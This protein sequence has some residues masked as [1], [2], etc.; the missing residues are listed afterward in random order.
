MAGLT[1]YAAS[2][3]Y[4]HVF[5]KTSTFP[6]DTQLFAALSKSWKLDEG[7]LDEQDGA[8]YSRKA[9][10]FGAPSPGGRGSNTSPVIFGP[11]IG[12]SSWDASL[13]LQIMELS[14]GGPSRAWSVI[15]PPWRVLLNTQ[16]EFAAG[17]I[18]INL[19][20][21]YQP[22]WSPKDLP[23]LWNWTWAGRCGENLTLSHTAPSSNYFITEARDLS[24]FGRHFIGR[25]AGKAPGYRVGV[26]VTDTSWGR[27]VWD[28]YF[29]LLGVHQFANGQELFGNVYDFN[30]MTTAGSFHL[31]AVFTN[32]RGTGIRDLWGVTDQN[33]V[34][35]DQGPNRRVT[36]T[37][38]G[39]TVTLANGT[40]P[41]NGLVVLEVGRNTDGTLL[42]YA[43]GVNIKTH[44]GTLPG[45]FT[46]AGFGYKGSGTSEWDDYL[47]ELIVCA[48]RPADSHLKL[49]R[50]HLLE[51][52]RHNFVERPKS[53]ISNYLADRLYDMVFRG[54]NFTPPANQR[55]AL[56]GR[57]PSRSDSGATIHEPGFSGY[58][59]RIMTWS[60]DALAN[61]RG[62]SAQEAFYAATGDATNPL[63]YW[64]VVDHP[65]VGQGNLLFFAP[66]E[67]ALL[68]LAG[69][70]YRIRAK[71]LNINLNA[72]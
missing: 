53:G 55:I 36:I 71:D 9:V 62:S 35:I 14:A 5:S 22:V 59:R 42:C 2:Q 63:A 52:W 29:P 58:I 47:L 54:I 49:L 51:K 48:G 23:A 18:G 50:Q 33:L 26:S 64:G 20:P 66:L 3:C 43:N 4:R 30:P 67:E 19:T 17:K 10:T 69:V 61:G 45:T 25:M 8:G 13:A 44:S 46:V 56:I 68:P 1:D 15:R 12:S 38:A 32:S 40:L 11:A 37:I 24:G 6:L 34:T 21:E 72:N 39:Q 28:T 16:L 27:G 70:N 7:D 57:E 65:D 31:T 60:E 41:A